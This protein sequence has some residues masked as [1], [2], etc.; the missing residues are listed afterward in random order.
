MVRASRSYLNLSCPWTIVNMTRSFSLILQLAPVVTTPKSEG[1]LNKSMTT[2]S[3]MFVPIAET[4]KKGK[5]RHIQS[6]LDKIKRN[7]EC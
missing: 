6:S 4:T 5:K 3:A 7:F 2:T 1:T